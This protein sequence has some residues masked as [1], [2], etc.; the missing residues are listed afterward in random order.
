MHLFVTPQ[1]VLQGTPKVVNIPLVA[2]EAGS[3][4]VTGLQCSL[5]LT[6]VSQRLRTPARSRPCARVQCQRSLTVLDRPQHAQLQY[7]R[8][9]QLEGCA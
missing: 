5:V 2:R 7:P 4:A 8:A 3:E 9:F 1:V 6:Q